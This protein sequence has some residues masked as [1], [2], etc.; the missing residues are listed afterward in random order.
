MA[1]SG[2]IADIVRLI[3]ALGNNLGINVIAEGVE[4]QAQLDF[5]AKA[6]C[7]RYQGFL[8]KHALPNDQFV[9]F[10]RTTNAAPTTH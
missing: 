9:R 4:T 7:R 6:G 3:I 5:L 10:A 8:Y 1:A 2:R